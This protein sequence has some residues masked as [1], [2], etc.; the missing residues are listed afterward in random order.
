M[1]STNSK[2]NVISDFLFKFM[3]K[4]LSFKAFDKTFVKKAS[5]FF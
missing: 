2:T 5:E 3:T 1:N 4:V